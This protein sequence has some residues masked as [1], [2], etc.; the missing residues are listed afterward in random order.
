MKANNNDNQ[1]RE[2]IVH[3]TLLQHHKK[4]QH[5]KGAIDTFD[6][7]GLV[8]F[9]YHE[10]CNIDLFEQGFGMST[11]TKIMTSK[12][13]KLTLFEENSW[14]KDLDL[15][16]EGDILFFHRQSLKENIPTKYNKYPGHCGIYLGNEKF[17]HASLPKQE[18]VI[19]NFKKNPYWMQVLVASKDIL[20]DFENNIGYRK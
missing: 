14:D 7:S 9:I 19:S 15:I 10:I 20:S 8:W 17:I 3:L 2:E 11:T 6:C 16:K 18:V 13:G 12:Y 5:G 1:L 4:Y